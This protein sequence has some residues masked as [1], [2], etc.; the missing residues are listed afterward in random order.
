MKKE[1]YL[2]KIPITYYIDWTGLENFQ[3]Y[4]FD[5][6]GIPQV[7]CFGKTGVYY[8]PITIAQYGLYLL[9]KW[10]TLGKESARRLAFECGNWLVQNGQPYKFGSIAWIYDFDLIFYNRQAPWIS[11]MAQGEAISLL[12][13]LNIL[14]GNDSFLSTV[15]K[16]MN[17]FRHPVEE[18]GVLDY[19]ENGS[20][21]FQEYPSVP[22]AHVFNG[23]VFSLLGL[24]DYAQFL[25]DKEMKDLAQAGLR[26]L[27]K[28][29][30][31][32]DT[33]Y[34]TRY[35][36]FGPQRLASPMYHEL[37]IRQLKVLARLFDKPN[38]L[39]VALRWEKY[40]RNPL[41]R[42]RWFF[43]K[44]KEKWILRGKKS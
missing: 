19:L 9:G 17:V 15:K 36:L 6:K 28:N 13:R 1:T 12:I 31:L 2:A 21:V 43:S 5:Q 16:A 29:W 37:H 10:E 30:G 7:N 33:G 18:G 23:H 34:W 14:Q 35:D 11:A 8:N 24:W 44:V 38:L 27:E 42:T 3:S 25:Q 4:I 22:P 32:W 40:Q 39:N 26:S 41:A 20:V